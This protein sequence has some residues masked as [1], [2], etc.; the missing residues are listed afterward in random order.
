MHLQPD[1]VIGIVGGMGPQ[2]GQAL[3]DRIIRN[4]DAA[5][6]QDHLSVILMSF[7]RYLPD[8][9]AFLQG[10]TDVNPAYNIA[11]MIASMETVGAKVIG[12][13]CNTSHAP[14]IFNVILEELERANSRVTFLHMPAET[15]RSLRADYPQVRRVGVMTT[16]GTYDAGLYCKLLE[17]DGYE[18]I[19]PDRRFQNNVIHRMIYDPEFG[20]K[21]HPA[22]IRKE[23]YDL[24]TQA[25]DFFALNDADAIILGCTELSLV[26]TEG[27]TAGMQI[28]DSTNALARAL[29]REAALH[30]V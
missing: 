22:F 20:I 28:V 21:S 4:T 19:L 16:N 18:A 12:M 9:T 7:P 30:P 6:D 13:A 25:L 27:K 14:A 29:V 23:V 2:A 24:L 5:M 15:C 26:L 3:F 10:R 11:W 1:R 17:Q 8:R